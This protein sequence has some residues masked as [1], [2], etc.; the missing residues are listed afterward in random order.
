MILDA[1]LQ[2]TGGTGG[3]SNGDGRNDKPTTGAQVSSN[4]L[5]LGIGTTAGSSLPPDV[6]TPFPQPGR[7]IGIGDDPAMKLLVQV[8]QAFATGTNMTV[9]FQGAP[10]S[11]T[12]GTP[13]AFVTYA[14]GP[15]VVTASLIVGARVLE[16]DWPRPSPGAVPPRYVQLQFTT[17]GSAMTAGLV[18]GYAVLD[19]HDQPLDA[20]AVLGGYIPGIVIAN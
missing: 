15:T 9:A 12:P 13:G 4:I 7:D 3:I 20:N 18:Q 5:D 8:T 19:R 11:G 17:T 14:T 16:I 10:A 6:T 1:L 2:F